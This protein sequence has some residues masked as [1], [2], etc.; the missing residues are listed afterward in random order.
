MKTNMEENAVKPSWIVFF[1]PTV[2]FIVYFPA[3]AAQ[4]TLSDLFF[5]GVFLWAGMKFF[6]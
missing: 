2:T 6:L 4:D 5:F 3:A 1:I